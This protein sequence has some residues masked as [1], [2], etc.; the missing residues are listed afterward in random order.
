MV[1]GCT[2]HLAKYLGVLIDHNLNFNTHLRSV[3]NK[4]SRAQGM[5]SKLKHYVKT[6]TL[7]SIYFSIFSS[8]LTYASMIWGQN[9]TV[10]FNRIEAIQNKTVKIL[11]SARYLD[12]PSISYKTLKILKIRDHI[13]LQNFMFTHD[14]L[15]KHTP[16]AIVDNFNLVSSRHNYET[17]L[18]CN[19]SVSLPK[20]NTTIFG[21]NNISYQSASEWNFF[22]K[23]FH[24]DLLNKSKLFCKQKILKHFL[25]SY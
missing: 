14:C 9:K 3:G 6:S 11:N 5:L 12:S 24:L 25:D 2:H 1:K 17:R 20:V 7:R 4:L 19:N 16:P 10:Q 13:K 23:K 22:I 15:I 8:I 21:L 18:S